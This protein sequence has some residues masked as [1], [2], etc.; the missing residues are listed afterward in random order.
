VDWFQESRWLIPWPA[1]R[2]LALPTGLL[3][4]AVR[5]RRRVLG[6]KLF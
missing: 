5:Q 6:R 2:R 4:S 3:R 1:A